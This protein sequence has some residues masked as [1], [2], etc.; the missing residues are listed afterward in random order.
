VGRKLDLA[1]GQNCAPGYEGADIAPLPGVQHIVNLLRFPWPFG[2]ASFE[3]VRTSHWLEHVPMLFWTPGATAWTCALT[4]F[5]VN[6]R[7][8]DLLLKV[9]DE[10]HRILVPG[11]TCEVLVP[12]AHNDRAFQDPTHRRF[13]VPAF[14]CYLDRDWRK[15][16]GLTHAA[17]DIACHFPL[18][19][20]QVSHTFT[21]E[22][23]QEALLLHPAALRARLDSEWNA[24]LDLHALLVK[25]PEPAKEPEPLAAAAAGGS[26]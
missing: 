15:A 10:I 9:F 19:Q 16:N 5:Q 13:F 6:E 2:D 12:Q 17:Y 22:A 14:F 26:A 8:V 25:A 1:C 3:A 20:T 23:E 7:S 24:A 4:S 21:D 11:G 18:A